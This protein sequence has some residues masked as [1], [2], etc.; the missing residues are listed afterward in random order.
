MFGLK[1]IRQSFVQ[2][3]HPIFDLKAAKSNVGH[4]KNIC[5]SPILTDID[6]TVQMYRV[7]L[8]VSLEN[9]RVHSVALVKSCNQS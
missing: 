1:W 2:F 9:V 4:L 8:S 3:R 7:N 5:V 6:S